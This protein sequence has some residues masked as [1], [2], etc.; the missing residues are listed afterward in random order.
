LTSF[1]AIEQYTPL[2]VLATGISTNETIA[3]HPRHLASTAP[4]RRC[5]GAATTRH[6]RSQAVERP[7]SVNELVRL[8]GSPPIVFRALR[9]KQGWPLD[10]A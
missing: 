6:R 2:L 9:A 7:V 1:F 10:E 5:N 4:A 8:L 3:C